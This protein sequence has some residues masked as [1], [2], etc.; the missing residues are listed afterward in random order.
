MEFELKMKMKEI[1]VR[2]LVVASLLLKFSILCSNPFRV[3]IVSPLYRQLQNGLI[4]SVMIL[5]K[6]ALFSTG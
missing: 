5:V 3:K 2:T 4:L 1:I 6:I